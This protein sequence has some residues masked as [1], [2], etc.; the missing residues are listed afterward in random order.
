MRY[1][2]KY[3]IED[4]SYFEVLNAIKL[5][6]AS[7]ITAY[8]DRY[9]NSLYLDTHNQDAVRDNLAGISQRVKHRI[10]W[11]GK[12]ISVAKNPQLE[13]KIKINQLGKKEYKKLPDFR[14]MV[15]N[16]RDAFALQDYIDKNIDS[17]TLLRPVV[18]IQYIRSYLVSMDRKYRLTLDR[19]LKYYFMDSYPAFINNPA[20]E[21]ATIVEIKYD[22]Q[23]DED[24]DYVSQNMAFRMGKS[25]KY[26]GG[27]M[28]CY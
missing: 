2:R 15:P 16:H 12:D 11:Y 26:V 9:V 14:L 23:Y 25:L 24:W 22:A 1:E 6:P 13:K 19:G 20:K 7:F 28:R 3:K 10:R 4:A 27:V 18:L 5:H 21:S 17:I 8:P